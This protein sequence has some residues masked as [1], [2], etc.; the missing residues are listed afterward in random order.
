MLLTV[1]RVI[2]QVYEVSYRGQHITDLIK[3][4]FNDWRFVELFAKDHNR[5]IYLLL[6]TVFDMRFKTK[7]QA[8][9]ELEGTFARFEV[10][11]GELKKYPNGNY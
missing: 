6:T 10:A 8:T 3:T 4:D 9:I 7:K 11:K 2:P 5:S 1:K